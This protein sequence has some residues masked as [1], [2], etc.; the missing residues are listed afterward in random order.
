MSKASAERRLAHG[1]CRKNS[2]GTV[3]QQLAKIAIVSLDNSGQMV[4]APWHHLP[5]H[6][7]EPCGKVSSMRACVAFAGRRGESRSIELRYAGM[8][9][10]RCAAFIVPRASCKLIIEVG[11]V[12]FYEG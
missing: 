6:E 10:R 3:D 8:V 9:A 4:L 1:K 7:G 11:N 5:R 12:R 2:S